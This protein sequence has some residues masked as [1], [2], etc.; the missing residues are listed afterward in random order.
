MTAADKRPTQNQANLM[1]IL[2]YQNASQ[3]LM[4][5]VL[6]PPAPVAVPLNLV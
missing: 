1:A 2:P 6:L 3:P 4:Y 5:R